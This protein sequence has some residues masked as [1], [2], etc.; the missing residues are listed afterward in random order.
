[1]LP[2]PPSP[3]RGVPAVVMNPPAAKV[4]L[5][6]LELTVMEPKRRA[7]TRELVTSTAASKSPMRPVT[8][9]WKFWKLSAIIV[10]TLPEIRAGAVVETVETTI[11]ASVGRPSLAPV[12]TKRSKLTL[13]KVPATSSV[14]AGAVTRTPLTVE[15]P[16]SGVTT[17]KGLKARVRRRRSDWRRS[18]VISPR[19]TMDGSP[20]TAFPPVRT[21]AEPGP[22]LVASVET[23]EMPARKIRDCRTSKLLS[24]IRSRGVLETTRRRSTCGGGTMLPRVVLMAKVR[25]KT[26]ED[27]LVFW[28]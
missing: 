25:A 28:S 27:W 16:R 18:P 7:V 4:E 15:S 26:R 2:G 20:V 9:A 12:S 23:I 14:M 3:R 19:R 11:R 1:M 13:V 17:V 10:P 22:K 8:S 6:R 24:S 5:V 21:I